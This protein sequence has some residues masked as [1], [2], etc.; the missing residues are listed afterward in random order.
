MALVVTLRALSTAIRRYSERGT[1]VLGIMQLHELVVVRIAFG[2]EGRFAVAVD[3]PA[4][5][6]GRIL[7][8]YFHVLDRAMAGLALEAAHL[9]VLRMVKIGQVG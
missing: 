3:A 6:E 2:V 7:V 1:G 4:H 8:H 5:G 9:R